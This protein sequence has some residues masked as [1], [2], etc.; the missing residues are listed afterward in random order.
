[1]IVALTVFNNVDD[2]YVVLFL[3]IVMSHIDFILIAV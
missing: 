1:M 3:F 2:L